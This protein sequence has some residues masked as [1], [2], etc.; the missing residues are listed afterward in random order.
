MNFKIAPVYCLD[1]VNEHNEILRTQTKASEE[2]TELVLWRGQGRW[3]Q[4]GQHTRGKQATQRE[5][6]R[7]AEGF[8]QIHS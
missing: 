4:L 8:P 2:D 6:E 5:L 3:S 1:K 7:P